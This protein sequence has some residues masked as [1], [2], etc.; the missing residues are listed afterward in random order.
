M[1]GMSEAELQQLIA[2]ARTALWQDREVKRRL[3]AAG[4][5]LT[6]ANFYSSVPLVQEVEDSFELAEEDVLGATV[7]VF[8]T[9]F[10][11]LRAQLQAAAARTPDAP[12]LVFPDR[13]IELTFADVVASAA[14][15]A[16]VLAGHG[17]GKGDV[18]AFAA[19]N[20]PA[21]TVAWW[22]TVVSGA[23]VSSLNGWW[24]PHEL[25]YGIELTGPKVLIAD[26]RRLE[27]LREAGVPDGLV[28]IEDT[29]LDPLLGIIEDASGGMKALAK[30]TQYAVFRNRVDAEGNKPKAAV[31]P[32]KLDFEAGRTS[33]TEFESKKIL[34]DFG[35]PVTGAYWVNVRVGGVERPI[36]FQVFERRVLTYNPANP[37]GWQIEM[38]NV[39]RHYFEWRY[40][41]LP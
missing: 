18:V 6:P 27:R 35:L 30:L 3:Q 39:G 29:E 11:N 10:P 15:I 21:Y 25:V 7:T 40:G 20:V 12:Y 28:L 33:L 36:L 38:G 19:A 14:R 2:L 22:S 16:E 8:K 34:G 1:A 37:A 17:V 5:N 24:T 23:V 41:Y 13:G 9:R 4:V 31:K 26:A 32:L